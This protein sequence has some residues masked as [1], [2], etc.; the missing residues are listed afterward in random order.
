MPHA[1]LHWCVP[2]SRFF[3]ERLSWRYRSST[4]S[5]KRTAMRQLRFSKASLISWFVCWAFR[6]QTI[7]QCRWARSRTPSVDFVP[8]LSKHRKGLAVRLETC[9][10][11]AV[12]CSCSLKPSCRNCRMRRLRMLL[13]KQ[14]LIMISSDKAG[15]TTTRRISL[16]K[17]VWRR[18]SRLS[19]MK[20]LRRKRKSKTLFSNGRK[21]TLSFSLRV[22][23][24]RSRTSN[25]E[26]RLLRAV[27]VLVR[28][29]VFGLSWMCTIR[30]GRVSISF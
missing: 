23:Q 7:S 16:L 13:R 21:R 3:W 20:C 14:R 11:K 19:Q 26:S 15:T 8:L 30:Y 12:R 18:R 10:P 29:P 9:V 25:I 28:R 1:C 2:M 17:E 24:R 6:P 22:R 4:K 27:P 5:W